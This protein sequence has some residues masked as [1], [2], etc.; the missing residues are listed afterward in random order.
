MPV[1]RYLKIL[2]RYGVRLPKYSDVIEK[3]KEHISH[4]AWWTFYTHGHATGFH[5]FI[6]T[7]EELDWLSAQYPDTFDKYYRPL[8]ELAKEKEAKGERFYTTGLPQLCQVCQI[9]MLFTEMDNPNQNSMR[10]TIYEGERYH[11]CSDG[12]KGHLRR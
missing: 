6:P 11:C 12:C 9:P 4:Q 1:V 7:D 8:W 2:A 3:E 5:T 10:D